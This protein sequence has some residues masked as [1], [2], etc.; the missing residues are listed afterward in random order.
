[1]SI[2]IQI[3]TS[4]HPCPYCFISLKDLKTR[5]L[6]IEKERTFGDLQHDYKKYREDLKVCKSAAAKNNLPPLHNITVIESVL[7]EDP[8]IKFLS[9][10]ILTE[11]H[12]ILGFVNHLFRDGLCKLL[13]TEKA[14]IWPIKL[15]QVTMAAL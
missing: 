5:K 13:G 2:G 6:E 7:K 15:N 4:S 14:L 1:M 10:F 3:S 8:D 12:S 9:K 11:L